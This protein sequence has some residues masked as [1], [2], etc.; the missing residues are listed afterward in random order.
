M[1]DVSGRREQAR[2]TQEQILEAAERRFLSGGYAATTIGAI[3]GDV[4][5]SVDT[6]Y[7]TFRGKPGLIRAIRSR[8]LLGTGPIP[9]EQR[10]D[11]L[12]EHH[13]DPRKIIEG[14]GKLVTE[15]APRVSPISLLVR[16][17]AASDPELRALL[18]ESDRGR[19]RRMTENARRLH[20]AGHLRPEITVEYAA[21][22]LW[23]YSSP[24]LYEL[25]VLRRGMAL[26]DYGRFVASAMI[27]ALLAPTRS[28]RK[29]RS[30]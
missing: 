2:R 6:I 16:D 26:D 18:D 20:Q 28:R 1:Y 24:E 13:R 5:V 25:L 27:S 21:D 15:L 30:E 3:A 22:V 11:Q 23:T 8:A 29:T 19:L 7:K 9:A 10:S 4:A 14:W 17:A 12:H